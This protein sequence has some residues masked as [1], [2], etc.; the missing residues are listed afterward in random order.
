MKNL[1]VFLCT[2]K[3]LELDEESSPAGELVDLEVS[4]LLQSIGR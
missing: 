1:G 3:S 2:L 4:H